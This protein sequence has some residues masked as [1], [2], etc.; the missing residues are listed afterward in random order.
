M[1]QK[2]NQQGIAHLIPL[3][4]IVAVVGVG[5]SFYLYSQKVADSKSRASLA[6]EDKTSAAEAM[7]ADLSAI[8]PIAEITELATK[9]EAGSTVR[10]VELEQE[11][12]KLV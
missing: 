1:K 2:S 7:P 12:G 9:T 11:D 10:E 3:V 8:K 5:G 6:S 4:A